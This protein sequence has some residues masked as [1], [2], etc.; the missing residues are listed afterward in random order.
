[1]GSPK[2]ELGGSIRI[3]RSPEYTLE[4]TL[5]GYT[6]LSCGSARLPEPPFQAPVCWGDAGSPGISLGQ[7][8]HVCA[9]SS[10]G[11]FFLGESV[12]LLSRLEQ[13]TGELWRGSARKMWGPGFLGIN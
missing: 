13:V 7:S 2:Q 9:T 11:L 10:Q 12:K 6:C 8:L 3:D 5:Q 1:M 4:E